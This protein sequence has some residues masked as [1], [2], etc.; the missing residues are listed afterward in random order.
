MYQY[1]FEKLKVWQ[2]SRKLAISV[3]KITAAF[4]DSERFGLVNQMQRSAVSVSSNIAEG[5]S[6]TSSK[7]Q[8]HF[9]QLAYSSLMELL[10]QCIISTDLEFLSDTALEEIRIEIE[11]ISRML[12][13]LRRSKLGSKKP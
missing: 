3:Y 8:A 5:S 2:N 13:S 6:R 1:G 10:N 12:N 9:Y 7:D 11:E 4:P